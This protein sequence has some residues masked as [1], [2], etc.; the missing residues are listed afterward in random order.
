DQTNLRLH[1]VPR[2][3]GSPKGEHIF[4]PVHSQTSSQTQSE[5][6]DGLSRTVIAAIIRQDHCIQRYIGRSVSLRPSL[7]SSVWR[8]FFTASSKSSLE[9]GLCSIASG[10]SHGLRSNSCTGK[11][12]VAMMVGIDMRAKRSFPSISMPVIR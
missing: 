3:S 6:V 12:L 8:T 10:F 4:Q 5:K 1:C 2:D 11:C 7:L 9:N